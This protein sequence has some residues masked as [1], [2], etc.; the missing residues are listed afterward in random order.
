MKR[1]TKKLVLNKET[2]ANLKTP[3]MKSALGGVSGVS[4]DLF[5]CSMATV[6]PCCLA[7]NATCGTCDPYHCM[8]P[9]L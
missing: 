9:E 4:C 5:V 1:F 6:A 2:V 8:D 3:E 7:T